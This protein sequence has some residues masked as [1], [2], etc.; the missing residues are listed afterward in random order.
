M[1]WP[2]ISN[3]RITCLIILEID[4]KYSKHQKN[5]SHYKNKDFLALS[6]LLLNFHVPLNSGETIRSIFHVIEIQLRVL[7]ENL[8]AVKIF[9]PSFPDF[10]I[11]HVESWIES[12]SLFIGKNVQWNDHIF[13]KTFLTFQDTVK[14]VN[15]FV[16]AWTKVM[17]SDRYEL[18]N[19]PAEAAAAEAPA[20]Q[21]AAPAEAAPK[22]QTGCQ[23]LSSNGWS[24]VG[25]VLLFGALLRRK[26]D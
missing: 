22:A 15:D 24:W 11:K 20:P 17:T 13:V 3:T 8:A 14:L 7:A 18:S 12:N 1:D 4:Q 2:K 16:E 23:A 10:L 6:L 25:G 21:A 9:G 26:D 5:D 19:Q